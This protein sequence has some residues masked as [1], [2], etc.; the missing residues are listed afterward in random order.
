MD[1]KSQ[2]D[3]ASE[4]VERLIGTPRVSSVDTTDGNGLNIDISR[5]NLHDSKKDFSNERDNVSAIIRNLD[6][7][8][9]RLVP[10]V[11]DTDQ[12]EVV[13]RLEASVNRWTIRKQKRNLTEDIRELVMRNNIHSGFQL[14]AIAVM[15]RMLEAY[16]AR[17]EEL[18]D[19]EVDFWSVKNRP[20]NYYARTIA[21]RLARLYAN[22]KGKFPSYGTSGDGGH[23]STDYSR[24]LE[25]IFEILDIKAKVPQPAK[26]AVSQLKEED[27]I[28]PRNRPAPRRIP[29]RLGP[30]KGS[31]Q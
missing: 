27:K 6:E 10:G 25:E 9:Q 20:P 15:T 1:Y 11:D 5:P 22:E 14:N 17:L 26:W 29:A 28:H 8:V 21:L 19:Q 7:V 23:A 31:R 12:M 3:A 24:A 2:D 18:T 16:R 30:T 13:A 4:V